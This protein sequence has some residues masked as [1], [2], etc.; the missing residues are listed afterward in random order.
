MKN[1]KIEKVRNQYE[2]FPYPEPINDLDTHIKNN[3]YTS[4]PAFFWERLWPEKKVK[5]KI[6]I[7][8]AGCGSYEAAVI[9]KTNPESSVIGIDLSKTS[10]ECNKKLKLKYNLDNLELHC[11]DFRNY[12]STKK[13]DLISSSGVIH[14]LED[15]ETAIKFFNENLQHDGVVNLMVYGNRECFALRNICKVFK[16]LNLEQNK[17]SI[18]IIKNL[19][20]KLD[21]KHPVKIFFYRHK[22]KRTD[23]EIVDLFLHAQET[24]FSIDELYELL[25]KNNL[26]IKNFI[27]HNIDRTTQFFADNDELLEKFNSL[28]LKSKLE[29]GQILNWD[30]RK[31]QIICTKEKNK[32]FGI[33]HNNL[34][35]L[36]F[37]IFLRCKVNYSLKDQTL[38]FTNNALKFKEIK[39]KV[40]IEDQNLYSSY[41]SGRCNGK[42]FVEKIE[43]VSKKNFTNLIKIL[44]E[45]GFLDYSFNPR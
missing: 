37:Y 3:I 10:I 41:F 21:D 14:H 11:Q 16:V 23:A 38:I 44:K 45:N 26:I 1:N 20:E 30:D 8:I 22:R 31:I 9:A 2:N 15:P 19:I 4:D 6:N 7:L 32:K 5:K 12:N 42:Q 43:K 17:K 39:F 36:N 18:S 33:I 29:V 28:N 34:D 24:F 25:I 35:I 13:F 27:T 40:L